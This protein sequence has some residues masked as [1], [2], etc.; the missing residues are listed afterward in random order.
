M[1][2]VGNNGHRE[3][4]RFNLQFHYIIKVLNAYIDI[5]T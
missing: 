4:K 2:R 1:Q 5:R 3:I